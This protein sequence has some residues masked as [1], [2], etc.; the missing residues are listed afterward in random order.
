[1]D[2][3]IFPSEADHPLPMK[4]RVNEFCGKS[5]WYKRT[6]TSS[7]NAAILQYR[8]P[9]RGKGFVISAR[10]PKNPRREYNENRTYSLKVNQ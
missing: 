5:R 9:M 3:E 2:G 7:Q 1:M 4:E 8:I 10:Y 6:F